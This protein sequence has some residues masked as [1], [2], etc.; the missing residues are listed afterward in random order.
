MKGRLSGIY[1][2]PIKSCR[3]VSCDTATVSPIG[4]Q[5]DRIWQVVDAEDR[6]ITQRRHRVLATVQPEL[7]DDDGLRLMA[8]DRPTIEIDPPGRTLDDGQV[9]LRCPGA[10]VRCRR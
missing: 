8:P 7:R 9:A 5:G 3:A 2:H 6:G 4:L 1:V 10:C